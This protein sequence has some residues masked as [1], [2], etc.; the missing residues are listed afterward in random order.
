MTTLRDQIAAKLHA[1][2]DLDEHDVETFVAELLGL[3]RDEA[4]PTYEIRYDVDGRG[5]DW[6]Y[7][8]NVMSRLVRVAD[9]TEEEIGWDG[10]E[11]EDQCLGRD[12][13]W[14]AVALERAEQ[15][16]FARGIASGEA[17]RAELQRLLECAQKRIGELHDALKAKVLELPVEQMRQAE[18]ERD[19][20]R[21]ELREVG[22][23]ILRD[24]TALTIYPQTNGRVALNDVTHG[25]RTMP[26]DGTPAGI[27]AA[28][29][30]ARK[31]GAGK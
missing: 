28:L 12:W 17:E 7:P 20:A 19:A 31:A 24:G 4:P 26:W 6:K 10:G 30:A 14:V 9:G 15:G 21:E 27:I 1:T 8:S 29:L 3:L 11:P 23:A 2:W 5:P 16:A 25:T 18:R 13:A 22:E